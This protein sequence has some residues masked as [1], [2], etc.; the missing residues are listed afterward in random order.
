MT[1]KYLSTRQETLLSEDQLAIAALLVEKSL[2]ILTEAMP[3][4]EVVP[5]QEKTHPKW[6]DLPLTRRVG[7]LK[8]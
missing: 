3:D 7:S 6:T 2:W 4:M 5:S 1:L 8:I